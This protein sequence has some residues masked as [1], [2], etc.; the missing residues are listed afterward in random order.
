M[1]SAHVARS[2]TLAVTVGLAIA[3]MISSAPPASA[4]PLAVASFTCEPRRD[5][6]LCDVY[7][8]G[9]TGGYTYQW[10]GTN[11][12]TDYPDH[13]KAA[14][15]CYGDSDQVFV[16]ATDSSGST[17]EAVRIVKCFHV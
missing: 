17:V 6:S 8:S 3:G 7:F 10:Y 5:T 4:D 9:G 2:S 15:P 14:V 12:H 11:R 1:P 13:T 16:T